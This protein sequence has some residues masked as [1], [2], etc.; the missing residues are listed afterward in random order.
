MPGN[1]AITIKNLN[2]LEG[3]YYIYIAIHAIE[4]VAYDYHGQLYLIVVKSDKKDVGVFRPEDEWK[5]SGGF[6][7]STQGDETKI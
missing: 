6:L 3:Q 2:L 5:F 4:G 1:A 7:M